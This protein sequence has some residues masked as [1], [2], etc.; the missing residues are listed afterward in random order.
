MSFPFIW[1]IPDNTGEKPADF[2][3]IHYDGN[4]NS[5]LERNI[6]QALGM[7]AV[8]DPATYES[9][10][11]I[12]NLHQLE[13]LTHQLKPPQWPAAV[14][15]PIDEAKAQQGEQIFKQKCSDCH[16]NKLFAQTEIG[17]DPNRANSFGQLVGK[18]PFPAAVA[19][20]L[21]GLKSQ[22]LRR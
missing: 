20:I 3:W 14:L 4:T 1:N 17:T 13:V 19:P 2:Q 7:G 21:S 9:T 16:Q 5:I 22:G 10:L 18:K 15:G 11:R 8:F 6:G 12:G